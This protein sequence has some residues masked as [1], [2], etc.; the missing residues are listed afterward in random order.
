[1]VN[2]IKEMYI[3]IYFIDVIVVKKIYVQYAIQ[4]MINLIKLLIMMIE[5]IYVQ[6]IMNHLLNIVKHVIKIYALNVKLCITNILFLNL[7]NY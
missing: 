4:I 1:M 2:I 7:K 5:I 6:N 3:I